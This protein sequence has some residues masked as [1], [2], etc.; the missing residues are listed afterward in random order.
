MNG[1]LPHAQHPTRVRF[2]VLAVLCSLAFLTY[3]DRFNIT[4]VQDDVARDLR[5]GELSAADEA[6]V[7]GSP[8]ERQKRVRAQTLRYQGWMFS[9]FLLGYLLLEVPGG[10]LG[11]RLG[12]RAVLAG[13]VVFWSAFTLLTGYS[14]VVIGW[15]VEN[16]APVVLVAGVVLMRFFVGAGEAGAFPNVSRALGGWFPLA[17]RAGATGAVWMCSRLGGAFTFTITAWLVGTAN[18]LLGG[19]G[20]W[21]L[22]FAFYGVAGVLWAVLFA[23]W[24]RNRPEEM[25][26]ANAAEV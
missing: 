11:D 5:F 12:A 2:V 24:F 9:A 7:S 18:W 26:A 20:G 1:T 17:E 14:D 10:W 8:E 13:I 16:P 19:E 6:A 23:L 3:L 25:P 21:R 22:A 15:F 4:Q